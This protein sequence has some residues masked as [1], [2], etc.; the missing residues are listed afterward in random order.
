MAA[1][2]AIHGAVLLVSG[3]E[4]LPDSAGGEAVVEIALLSESTPAS[5]VTELS[6][7][8]KPER[9][10][11]REKQHAAAVMADPDT[12]QLNRETAR[13]DAQPAQADPSARESLIRSHLER[14]KYYPASA[15][16]RGITGEVGV[17]FELDGQ[18]QTRSLK[19]TSGSGYSLLDDAAL[20]TVHRAEPFPAD[21]GAFRFVL[22]FRAS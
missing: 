18:G 11:S 8:T 17:A 21:G 6:A 5:A 7:V 1:S 4:E 20:E 14:F 2:L 15:R 16:R 10:V 12:V 13:A 9:L 3:S 22:R 19:I